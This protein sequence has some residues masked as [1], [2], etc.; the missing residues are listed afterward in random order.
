MSKK[1]KVAVTCT[2][3]LWMLVQI[4][5]DK[6]ESKLIKGAHTV[7]DSNLDI[8]KV[9]ID[10]ANGDIIELT[11][12]DEDRSVYV[13]LIMKQKEADPNVLI[14][15]KMV[16]PINKWTNT[17]DGPTISAYLAKL[18]YV[19]KDVVAKYEDGTLVAMCSLSNSD[20]SGLAW[21]KGATFQMV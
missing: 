8:E 11:V 18:I 3:L 4:H 12:S 2:A 19:I 10:C 15:G 9:C 7:A 1:T 6:V 20:D 5:M 13:T 14:K 17:L 16:Y 21:C